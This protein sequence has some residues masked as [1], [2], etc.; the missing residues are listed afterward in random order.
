MCLPD[1][2]IKISKFDRL[3]RHPELKTSAGEIFS[4]LK[5]KLEKDK[6]SFYVFTPTSYTPVSYFPIFLILWAMKLVSVPPLIMLYIM[7]LCSLF[8]CIRGFVIRQ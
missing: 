1:S 6:T 7:R 5:I 2:V 8:F 4:A 3:C